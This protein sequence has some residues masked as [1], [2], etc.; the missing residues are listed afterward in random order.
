MV[1]NTSNN[2]IKLSPLQR[3][4]Y[5]AAQRV[6][7]ATDNLYHL[8]ESLMAV[9]EVANEIDYEPGAPHQHDQLLTTFQELGRYEL[10]QVRLTVTSIDVIRQL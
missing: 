1:A 5:Y 2:A 8:L 10:L 3:A 4:V 9:F 7:P 6:Q